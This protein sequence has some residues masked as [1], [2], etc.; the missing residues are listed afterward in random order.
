M[1]GKLW[2]TNIPSIKFYIECMRTQVLE[3]E[4]MELTAERLRIAIE[5]DSYEPISVEECRRL[6]K[7]G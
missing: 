3:C 1:I 4:G 2:H 6:L 5:E 7:E